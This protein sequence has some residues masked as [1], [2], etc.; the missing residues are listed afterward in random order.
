MIGE[1]RVVV[2]S[3]YIPPGQFDQMILLQEQLKKICSGNPRVVLGMDANA[4]SVLWDDDVRADSSRATKRMGELLVD[5]L[6]DNGLEILND[7]T[8][9]YHKGQYSAALTSLQ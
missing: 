7:G 8:H 1:V 9:T 3:V 6:L 4:R 5:I 2:G